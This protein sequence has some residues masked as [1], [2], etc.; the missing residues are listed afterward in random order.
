VE[1]DAEAKKAAEPSLNDDADFASRIIK[2]PARPQTAQRPPPRIQSN[3]R[4][5]EKV[6]VDTPSPIAR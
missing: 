1:E 2:Q 4:T 5:V 6:I 3:V